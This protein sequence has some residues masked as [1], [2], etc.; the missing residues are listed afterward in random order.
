MQ[1]PGPLASSWWE[2]GASPEGRSSLTRA[3]CPDGTPPHWGH[4]GGGSASAWGPL[5]KPQHHRA[6]KSPDGVPNSDTVVLQRN[7]KVKLTS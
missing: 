3:W 6:L 4:R 7:E 5:L 1:V 2:G